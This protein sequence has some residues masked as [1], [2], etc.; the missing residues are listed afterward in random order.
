MNKTTSHAITVA[1]ANLT[2]VTQ[3]AVEFAYI[4]LEESLVQM[5]MS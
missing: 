3:A 2:F 5:G 4:L 1:D